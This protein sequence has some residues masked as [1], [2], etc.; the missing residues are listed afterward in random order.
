MDLDCT[1]KKKKKF[2]RQHGICV[3]DNRSTKTCKK[4]KCYAQFSADVSPWSPGV[5]FHV[6]C[7]ENFNPDVFV[8]E[9]FTVVVLFECGF[10]ARK[11]YCLFC[12]YYTCVL[13][14]SLTLSHHPMDA[15]IPSFQHQCCCFHSWQCAILFRV[16]FCVLFFLRFSLAK[17]TIH[18]FYRFEHFVGR[19]SIGFAMFERMDF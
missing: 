12:F 5:L 10:E 8:M 7:P 17:C 3:N 16:L 1:R 2:E 18:F 19:K 14:F 15:L 13:I 4:R 6:K 11:Q 9:N